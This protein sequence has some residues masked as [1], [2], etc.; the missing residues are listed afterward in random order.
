MRRPGTVIAGG[1]LAAVRCVET[2]RRRGYE[3]PITMVCAEDELPYDRPP[4]S[5]E[6]LAGAMSGEAPLLHPAEWYR[7][8]DVEVIRGRAAACVAPKVGRLGLDDG[9]VLPYANLLVATG[10]RARTLPQLDRYENVHY[11][12]TLADA[13]R[14]SAGLVHGA[15]LAIVGAGFIGQEVAATARGLGCDVTMIEAL[16]LPLNGL[17]GPRLGSWFADLHQSEGVELLLGARLAGARGQSR[18]EELE[19]EDGRRIP[20]D[21]VVVG[22]GAVPNTQ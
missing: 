2:L 3:G 20:C 19:L 5:K 1:G 11:L 12:R 13:R 22:V 15:R 16:E 10:S 17:L 8:Q 7:T 9:S 14:L 6:L 18:V 21:V 4:L